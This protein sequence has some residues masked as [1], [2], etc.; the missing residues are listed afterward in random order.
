MSNQMLYLAPDNGMEEKDSDSY[1]TPQWLF[2][3]LDDEYDFDMDVCASDINH[4]CDTYFT[5]DDSGLDKNWSD[6]GSVAFC[7]PPYSRGMKEKFLAK[8]YQEMIENGV[9]SVF[10]IPADICNFAWADHVFIKAT[11]VTAITGKV[12]FYKPHTNEESKYG[13]G[14]SVVEFMPGELPS[15]TV[16]R[17]V[18]R[19]DIKSRWEKKQ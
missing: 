13:L 18:R 19:D 9:A 3:W 11:K 14:V 1:G 10:V 5:I 12:R 15:V 17:M 4:K 7:N 16:D 6:Y 8:A 2:D